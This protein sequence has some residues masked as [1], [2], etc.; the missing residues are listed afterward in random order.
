MKTVIFSIVFSIHNVQLLYLYLKGIWK[1]SCLFIIIHVFFCFKFVSVMEMHGWYFEILLKWADFVIFCM[2]IASILV[3]SSVLDIF[4]RCLWFM[5]PFFDWIFLWN[6][7]FL[8]NFTKNGFF[9]PENQ[10]FKSP[11]FSP[12]YLGQK[13]QNW[14]IN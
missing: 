9:F 10:W 11:G 8:G 5:M 14:H 12:R 3:M 6:L 13:R 4:Y 2:G 7:E 1:S